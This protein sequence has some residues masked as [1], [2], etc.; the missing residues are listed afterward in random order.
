MP[1]KDEINFREGWRVIRR[2]KWI[3]VFSLG[4]SLT[5]AFFVNDLTQ[6]VFL[7]TSQILI[8]EEP[9]RSPLTGE[10]LKN[11][12][13]YSESRGF[14]TFVELMT[15]R[16]HMG[17]VIKDLPRDLDLYR[18]PDPK[19][20]LHP[21]IQSLEPILSHAQERLK[22]FLPEAASAK[23]LVE[24]SEEERR[25]IEFNEQIDFLLS[26]ISVESISGTRLV[27]TYV[28][29]YDPAVSKSIADVVARTFIAYQSR[30]HAE[31]NI[32]L[33]AFPHYAT[34]WSSAKKIR[35]SLNP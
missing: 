18:S 32:D 35:K 27:N 28:E 10:V 11:T 33:I 9:T 20:F 34:L 3:I 29:H 19:G 13:S 1:K 25:S 22:Q 21:L 31:S 26:R 15:S 30:Q 23:P 8:H 14:H 12:G 24:I 7:A 17:R 5:V 4:F 2:R 6:P 16:A